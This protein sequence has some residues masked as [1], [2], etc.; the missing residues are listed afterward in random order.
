MA[1]CRR[2]LHAR[3][4]VERRAQV[5]VTQQPADYLVLRWVVPDVQRAGDMPELVRRHADAEVAFG[6]GADTG[7][8]RAGRD[9][10]AGQAREQPGGGDL[11]Q[12]A[13]AV[14]EVPVDK[15]AYPGGQ[16]HGQLDGILNFVRGEV[17]F[18]AVAPVGADPHKVPADLDAR[19]VQDPDR[20]RKKDGHG[21]RAR[22]LLAAHPAV[23]RL[24]ARKLEQRVRQLNQAQH[25]LRVLELPQDAPVLLGHAATVVGCDPPGELA[26][27]IE[28]R[29]RD[30]HPVPGDDHDLRHAALERG[31]ALLSVMFGKE[32]QGGSH[33]VRL[34]EIGQAP[35]AVDRHAIA[36][37]CRHHRTKRVTLVLHRRLPDRPDRSS[38][39]VEGIVPTRPGEES[40]HVGNVG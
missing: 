20:C 11:R 33:R 28:L 1:R 40:L 10:P 12:S 4:E 39:V 7:G 35:Q 8:H 24:P 34:D 37:R 21:H 3:V 18:V 25:E 9:G 2:L 15:R 5:L 16:G 22:L 27:D 23:D 31:R 36:D 6:D 13:P 26:Q 19:E 38:L 17:E 30:L 32:P 29:L 14:L